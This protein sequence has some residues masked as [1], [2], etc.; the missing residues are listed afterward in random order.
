M[1]NL[2][3]VLGD[4]L[5]RSSA[6]FDGFDAELDSVWMAEVEDEATHVWCHKLRLAAFFSAMRHFRD[7]LRKRDMKVI[8]HELTHR[9]SDDSGKNFADLLRIAVN[10]HHPERLIILEPG[11]YRVRQM[12]VNQAAES[13]V[14]VEL[15]EDD[16]FYCGITEFQRWAKGRKRLVLEDFYRHLRTMHGVLVSGGGEPVGGDWNFD[17]ENRGSFGSDGPGDIKA[18]RSFRTDALT[19]EVIQMVGRRYANHPGTLD[20]FDLPVTHKQARALLRDFIQHRLQG[21][22]TWQD[23]IWSGR[24]FLYHSRLSFALNMHLLR[25]RDCVDA[26]IEAYEAGKAPLN[27][28]EG[29][30]RQILGWREFVRGIYWREMPEYIERNALQCG[31]H[32]V[33]QSYWDGET[34]MECIRDSMASVLMHGYAHHIQRLMILGLFCQLL[35]VHPRKFH[36]WH[37]AMYVDAID[38]VSLPNTLGM[39]QY[40]DGGL[41][42]TKPYCASGNYVNRMSNYCG[43][44]RYNFKT[45]T[46]GDA[47]PLTTLYWDFLDRHRDRFSKNRRMN[48]QLANLNRKPTE[49]LTSIRKQAAALKKQIQRNERI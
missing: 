39:S 44:C 5:D 2:I 46:G 49:E 14:E 37:M 1:R 38:W 28:V 22:G 3:L 27:S 17:S 23:A 32:E 9:R 48:Y 12:L 40:G 36:D 8:Y 30:V 26:A 10:K 25:P 16:H 11:D 43:S 29:F 45:A 42:G 18:P 7:E 34:D 19:D 4:Q 20:H 33:P 21:F 6:A 35:G 13:R 41:V 24:P 47:C 31:E 15:R